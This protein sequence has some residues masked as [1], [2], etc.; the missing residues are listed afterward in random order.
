[1]RSTGT[2]RDVAGASEDLHCV[3]RDLH[4]HVG[5]MAL[6]H[7]CQ[8]VDLAASAADQPGYLVDERPSRLDAD[9]HVCQHELNTLELA[10][11]SPELDSTLGERCSRVERG[12]GDAESQHPD[13]R[14]RGIEGVHHVSE[15]L[16]D[17]ADEIRVGNEHVVE[18]ELGRLAPSDAHLVLDP[19]HP[20]AGRRSIDDEAAD[21]LGPLVDTARAGEDAIDVGN[22]AVGHIDLGPV[23]HPSA[24]DALSTSRDRRAVGSRAGLREA[25]ACK[26]TVFAHAPVATFGDL[27]RSCRVQDMS[28]H[29]ARADGQCGGREAIGQLLD[30]EALGD[31]VSAD[32]PELVRHRQS[33]QAKRAKRLDRGQRELVRPVDLGDHRLQAATGKIPG[34]HAHLPLLLGDVAWDLVKHQW[35]PGMTCRRGRSAIMPA[36]RFRASRSQCH[37]RPALTS[38]RAVPRR[39]GRD[40]S[41]IDEVR[42]CSRG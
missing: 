35:P 4:R 10:H 42:G 11:R 20:Q 41:P 5:G 3:S 2:S 15:A 21:A 38:S 32:T 24:L 19:T 18:D 34:D 22:S 29:D 23:E 36:R 17:F 33:E 25:D 8:G 9:R 7:S 27:A 39:S 40:A 26:D 31:D 12:A 37:R 1:M 14:P 6:G 13:D 30:D 28:E 16:A